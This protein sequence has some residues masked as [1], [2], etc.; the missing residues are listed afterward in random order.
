MTASSI[1]RCR[2]VRRKD[3][4][5]HPISSE[6][7]PEE[8]AGRRAAIEVGDLGPPRLRGDPV[9]PEDL[10]IQVAARS[11]RSGTADQGELPDPHTLRVSARA[12]P[13][14]AGRMGDQS[15]ED[16]QDL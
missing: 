6:A 7:W 13:A 3:E 9:R 8:S 15:E 10:P 1:G 4:A 12:C 14:Q 11:G 16:L 5:D 2:R